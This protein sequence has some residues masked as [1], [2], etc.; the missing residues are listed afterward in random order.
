M[1]SIREDITPCKPS[2]TD[3]DQIATTR[4]FKDLA[5]TVASVGLI[6]ASPSFMGIN[7]PNAT[8]AAR[9]LN[10]GITTVAA[11]GATGD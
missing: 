6:L 4:Q 2:Q 10:K 1:N 3:W 8:G 11:S 5:T 9:Y 7:P